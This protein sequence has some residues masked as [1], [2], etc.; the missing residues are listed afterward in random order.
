MAALS[1]EK[2]FRRFMAWL[3]S[4]GQVYYENKVYLY[5][6]FC[7]WWS[8]LTMRQKEVIDGEFD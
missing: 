6:D 4:T 7:E 2:F 5:K 8:G 3:R 1:K